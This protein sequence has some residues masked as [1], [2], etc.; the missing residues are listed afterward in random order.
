MGLTFKT[1]YPTGR[2]R[3][4][5]HIYITIKLDTQEVGTIGW[6]TSMDASKTGMRVS[7]RVKDSTSACGWKNVTL[8][9][10][11]E[12]FSDKAQGKQAKEWV[13]A[14][15]DAIVKKYQ[16]SPLTEPPTML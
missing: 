13:K 2:Y 9:K 6:Q 11:F 10:T 5:D 3:S 4:F 12:G 1:N 8:K 7:L 15:W 14:N 16:L